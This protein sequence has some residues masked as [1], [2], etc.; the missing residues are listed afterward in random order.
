MD[1]ESKNLVWWRTKKYPNWGDVLNPVLFE[2]ISGVKPNYVAKNSRGKHR[3]YCIGSILPSESPRAEIW[4]SGFMCKPWP[5]RIIVP[6]KEIHAI[7]GPLSREIYR[8]RGIEC[9]EVYGDPAL[10]LPRYYFPKVEKKYKLGIIP[11]YVDQDNKWI[12]WKGELDYVN[13]IDI[14]SG[15]HNVV[16]EIL[17]CDMIISSSLHGVIAADAYGIPNKWVEFS[18]KVG[19]G[20]FKF[21]D[22][23]M[24]VGR[25]DRDSIRIDGHKMLKNIYPKMY[26]VDLKI[27]LDQLYS[28]CPFR[29]DL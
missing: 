19:G 22:Y 24:S 16:D 23:F 18:D 14:L 11:H 29:I 17:S 25:P 21:R 4:G 28:A 6:P 7:R 1:L 15:V 2:Y 20:G 13:V 9:P 5:D 3:Y 10:L 26:D 27:D 12:K 8:E